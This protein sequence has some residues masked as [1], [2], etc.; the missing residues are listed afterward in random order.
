[1]HTTEP[2]TSH[3]AGPEQAS[4]RT[5][6]NQSHGYAET[7]SSMFLTETEADETDLGKTKKLMFFGIPKA[8]LG[9]S[10]ICLGLKAE[11]TKES[12]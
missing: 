2:R 10:K 1:M 6:Y 5:T 8:F 12:Q 3:F 9:I 7:E 11:K 4:T